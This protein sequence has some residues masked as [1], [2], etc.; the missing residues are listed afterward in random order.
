MA[1]VSL[2]EWAQELLD[3]LGQ[4]MESERDALAS[5]RDFAE[6]A[7]DPRVRHL[8]EQILTDEVRHHQQMEE[9]RLALRDEIEQRLPRAERSPMTEEHRKELLRRTDELLT[10]ERGDVKELQRLAKQL[11]A[12]ADTEWQSA[13]VE[14]MEH[15]NRKHII[16]LERIRTLLQ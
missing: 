11:R 15:D 10:L 8:A 9:I 14:A 3:H 5:Y 12:V 6:Q 2:S 1:G 13:I 4:H 16:I 7:G